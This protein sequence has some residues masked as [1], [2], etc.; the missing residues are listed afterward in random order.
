[1]KTA[2]GLLFS[3]RLLFSGLAGTWLLGTCGWAQIEQPQLGW[4]L[5]SDAS[6]RALF[7]VPGSMTIGNPALAGVVSMGCSPRI[8]LM[9]TDSS[10]VSLSGAANAPAG[11]ALFSFSGPSALIYF[12]MVRQLS[13]WHEN[14]L[15]PI[16][17]DVTGDILSVREAHDG[18]LQFAVRNNSG[19]WVMGQ[20]NAILLA[21][22][23]SVGP[24]LL[25]G[26][27]VLFATGKGLVLRRPDATELRFSPGRVETL[28]WIGENYVQVRVP[29]ASYALRIDRGHERMFLL[30]EPTK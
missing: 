21:L 28:N 9:K 14:Q 12:P 10:I 3:F 6:A 15:A 8:C 20:G 17:F 24:V 25:L 18:T 4:M 2:F 27:G 29:G 11:P 1:M 7:G 26:D 22:P 23:G 5:S 19:T 30:P 16:D 13:G